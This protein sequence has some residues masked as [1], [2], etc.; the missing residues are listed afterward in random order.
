MLDPEVLE[1]AYDDA[2]ASDDYVHK[3]PVTMS[4][5][6]G[7]RRQ[8]AYALDEGWPDIPGSSGG[9]AYVGS[10]VHNW[11]LPDL[12]ERLGGRYEQDVTLHVEG[13]TISGHVDLVTPDGEAV[14]VKTVSAFYYPVVRRRTPWNHKLQTTGYALATDSIGCNLLYIDR[15]DPDNRFAVGWDVSRHTEDLKQ[16][17][18][19][20][21]R[22]PDQVPRD[23]Q[24]PGLSMICDSCPFARRCWG[25]L[26]DHRAPQSIVVDE[27]GAELALEE[28]DR[29]REAESEAKKEKAFWRAALDGYDPAEYGPWVLKWS[30]AS[31]EGWADDKDAAVRRLE[32]LGYEVPQ[33]K[34]KKS[35]SI[36]V[37]RVKPPPE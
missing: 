31:S 27:L 29:A 6:G 7:C 30:G 17:V 5:I 15:S 21:Q 36:N 14:D 1:A 18:R 10:A 3:T 9:A 20:V 12:A 35:P 32:E 2:V 28:Y 19:D 24:G 37:T 33:K 8:A 34:V 23:E 4:M 13:L 11:L 22:P 26:D 16:W 25:K